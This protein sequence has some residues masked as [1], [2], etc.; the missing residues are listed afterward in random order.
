AGTPIPLDR[1]LPLCG[2]MALMNWT[3]FL[4]S[5][6]VDTL[7]RQHTI[8]AV[9]TAANSVMILWLASTGG[10]LPGYG[11]SAIMLLFAFSFVSRTRFIF[12][13]WRSVV[14]VIGFVVA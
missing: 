13:A 11:M 1:A 5:E 2:V 6:A 7:D 14:I 3:P 9:L 4:L 10:V 12:A 8:I